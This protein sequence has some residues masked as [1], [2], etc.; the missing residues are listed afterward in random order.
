MS[1]KPKSTTTEGICIDPTGSRTGH[2]ARLREE[3]LS[4]TVSSRT[5]ELLL[6]LLLTYSIS[7]RDVQPLAKALL[8]RFGSLDKVLA[9]DPKALCEVNGIK[10]AT[11]ALL[12]LV[13]HLRQKTASGRPAEKLQKHPRSY[14]PYK[15][16]ERH[17]LRPLS[18]PN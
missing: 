2:R 8:S 16:S 7:Q 17:V 9:A 13:D 18:A 5:D 1:T 6:E 12:K 4:G 15:S 3:F 14:V 11:A 10:T